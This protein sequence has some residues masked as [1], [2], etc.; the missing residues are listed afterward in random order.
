MSWFSASLFKGHF[1][2]RCEESMTAIWGTHPTL[3]AGGFVG[4]LDPRTQL[5]DGPA[6]ENHQ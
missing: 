3:Q 5:P 2:L 1:A 4:F 6:F